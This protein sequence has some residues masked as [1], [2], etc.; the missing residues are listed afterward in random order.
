LRLAVVSAAALMRRIAQALEPSP[1]S[2]GAMPQR[3]GGDAVEQQRC[4]T[5]LANMP[6]PA[7][8]GAP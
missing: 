7:E 5:K 8:N 6:L 1:S 2:S 4:N 3:D